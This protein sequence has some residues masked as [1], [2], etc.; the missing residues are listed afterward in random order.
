MT[1]DQVWNQPVIAKALGRMYLVE[2][3]E[4][5]V[6]T[7]WKAGFYGQKEFENGIAHAIPVVGPAGEALL[8]RL[9]VV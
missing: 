1:P 8:A 4:D 5:G 7:I 6:I 2:R 9:E 3:R